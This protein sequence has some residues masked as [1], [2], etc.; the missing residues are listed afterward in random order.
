MTRPSDTT[1]SIRK[2]ARAWRGWLALWFGI[3][4]AAGIGIG[5]LVGADRTAGER[6]PPSAAATTPD[7]PGAAE[8]PRAEAAGLAARPLETWPSP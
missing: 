5:H 3:A 7:G 6:Q 1:G 2:T 8:P 4:V